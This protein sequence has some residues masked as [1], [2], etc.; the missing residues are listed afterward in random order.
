MIFYQVEARERVRNREDKWIEKIKRQIGRKQRSI[1][2]TNINKNQKQNIITKLQ[3]NI[4][5]N[6]LNIMK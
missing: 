1:D 4:D 6:S 2:Q 3:Q 5:Y